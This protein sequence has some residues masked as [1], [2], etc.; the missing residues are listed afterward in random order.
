MSKT[1]TDAKGIPLT[2]D[3]PA[4]GMG[5]PIWSFYLIFNSVL[6][7]L[8]LLLVVFVVLPSDPRA[9]DK[10][11][12]LISLGFGWTYL[13]AWVL[14]FC[15]M[16][17]GINLG[18]ARAKSKV[19]VPDQHV[20]QVKGAEGSKLGYVLMETEGAHGDFNRAQRALQNLNE[21]LPQFIAMYLLAS[22]VCPKAVFVC[23]CVF[24]FGRVMG[25]IGYTGSA[26]GRLGGTMIGVLGTSVIDCVV[27]RV[28]IAAIIGR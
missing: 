18:T 26:A 9:A 1:E 20:Y 5:I 21:N 22:Y 19:G 14:K 10:I 3:H 16:I 28:G 13:G 15:Q 12:S 2:A 25:A 7:S 23:A 11:S 17:I 27:L 6:T 24:G 4:I 8:G